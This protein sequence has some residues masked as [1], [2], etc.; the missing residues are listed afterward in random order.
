MNS[1]Q[2]CRVQ[3]SRAVADNQRA[4]RVHLGHSVPSARG[5]RLGAVTNHLAAVEQFG[6][7]RMGLEAL[8]LCVRIDEWIAIVQTGD[9]PQIQDPVLHSVDPAAA[10]RPLVRRKPES[11]RHASRWITVVGQFPKL[12]D[13]QAVNLWLASFIKTES[14][15]QLLRERTADAF[16][17]H[18]DL[19]EQIDTGLKVRLALP[20][21]VDPFVTRAHADDPIVRIVKHL[22][23]RKFGED[24][25]AGLFAL[26]AQ[27]CG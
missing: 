21:L 9:V 7:Q 18:R 5:D 25:D 23:A 12:F 3:K 24:V 14:L 2:S 8:E 10:I 6:Q 1:F 11:V 4:V 27:P 26:L 17:Q 13:A 15:N 22:S 19:R 16:A 20:F